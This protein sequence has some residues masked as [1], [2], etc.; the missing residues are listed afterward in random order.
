[1][2]GNNHKLKHFMLVTTYKCALDELKARVRP[3][4]WLGERQ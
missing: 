4:L 1:M 2:I 3:W